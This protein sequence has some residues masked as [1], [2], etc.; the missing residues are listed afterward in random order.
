MSE[1]PY[2]VYADNEDAESVNYETEEAQMWKDP[3]RLTNRRNQPSSNTIT[4]PR[5]DVL[6]MGTPRRLPDEI[7]LVRMCYVCLFFVSWNGKD[8]KLRIRTV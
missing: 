8:R 6:T 5:P 1:N 2:R 3:P 4:G 7:W